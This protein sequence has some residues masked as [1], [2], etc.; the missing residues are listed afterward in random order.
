MHEKFLFAALEQAKLG[1]GFCAPNPSVGAVAVKNGN[2]IAQSWHRGAGT[3]HAERLV[4]EQLPANEENVTLYVTLEPCNHFGRTPPCVDAIIHYGF[5]KVIFAYR[6]PNPI[7]AANHTSDKLRE[8]GIQV[9]QITLPEIDAFYQGYEYWTQTGKPWVTA[10]IAQTFDGKIAGAQSKRMTLSND[11]CGCFTHQNRLKNDIILTSAQTVNRDNP[12]FNVRLQGE[13]HSKPI[14]ILDRQL[15]LNPSSQLFL[16]AKHCHIF[17]DANLDAPLPVENRTY[18]P[19]SSEHDV[20]CLTE[21]VQQLGR[22]GFHYV[23]LE[24]GGRLFSA[25]HQAHL[26]NRTYIYLVPRILGEDAISAYHYADILDQPK[27]ISWESMG[28]NMIATVDWEQMR[29]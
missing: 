7:V 23:W 29:L 4:I 28:D 15:R 1:Q 5:E 18:Y 3:S 11:D 6:D 24:A 2:I 8:C 22:L 10:K 9:E 12:Q 17:Y 25:M 26:V 19:V 14:A 21:V 13:V 20:L 27:R 16:T